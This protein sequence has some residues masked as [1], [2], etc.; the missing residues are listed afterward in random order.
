MAERTQKLAQAIVDRYDGDAAAIWTNAKDGNDLVKRLGELPG[1][2]KQ[3]AQ[4]FTAL[5]GKQFGVELDGWREAAGTYGE[6][7]SLRSVADIVDA[8]SLSKVREFK[9]Q[10]KAQARSANG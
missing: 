7:G 5:L 10:M 9:K 6:V 2:G 4:I 3:K 8:G 1:F